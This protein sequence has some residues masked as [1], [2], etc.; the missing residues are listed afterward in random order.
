MKQQ[1]EYAPGETFV[2]SGTPAAPVS[3][4]IRLTVHQVTRQWCDPCWFYDKAK[5]ACR[6][7]ARE[8]P[9]SGHQRRDFR[10]VYY[11]PQDEPEQTEE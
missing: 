11:A 9:C 5:D 10:F 7:E 6:D 4:P 3:T 8:Y 2:F 1:R